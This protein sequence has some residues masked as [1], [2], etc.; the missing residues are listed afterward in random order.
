MMIIIRSDIVRY[1]YIKASKKIFTIVKYYF[2][3]TKGFFY[4]LGT[5]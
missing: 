2:A 1:Y 4:S 5:L 3:N